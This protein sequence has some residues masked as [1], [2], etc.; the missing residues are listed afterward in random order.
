M[1]HSSNFKR[2]IQKVS[3]PIS[4]LLLTV[5]ISIYLPLIASFFNEP[6]FKALPLVLFVSI[7][8]F[9]FD[10]V[11]IYV[12]TVIY[13]FLLT[14]LHLV[15]FQTAVAHPFG[16]TLVLF[17]AFLIF[18]IFEAFLPSFGFSRL[19]LFMLWGAAL[20]S[21]TIFLEWVAIILGYQST[22]AFL[23]NSDLIRGYKVTNSAFFINY[24]WGY[25]D[26]NGQ[27]IYGAN[28]PTLGSQSGS[29]LSLMAVFLFLPLL[30]IDTLTIRRAAVA[31]FV[32]FVFLATASMMMTIII[33]ISLIYLLFMDKWSLLSGLRLRL[34]LLL[35]LIVFHDFFISLIFYRIQNLADL[36][37]YV[38][39]FNVFDALFALNNFEFF[40]GSKYNFLYYSDA[41]L[42]GLFYFGGFCLF[43]F[44]ITPLALHGIRSH[45][46][47]NIISN[48]KNKWAD[49]DRDLINLNRIS[50]FNVGVCFIGLVHYSVSLE[51]G[52][53]QVF[54]FFIGLL[55][56]TSKFI[57]LKFWVPSDE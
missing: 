22:L 29:Q 51:L 7:F 38:N 55:M 20:V 16:F 9:C 10:K 39:A 53:A 1:T 2:F 54:S 37:E 52:I 3:C 17:Q 36:D 48:D 33:G 25:S 50:F 56:F 8:L 21:F 14:L 49:D 28:G 34:F 42:L 45:L 27:T 15:N 40:F 11:K 19:Y 30:K 18:K 44:W 31:T 23:F 13:F 12:H 4:M 57:F 47:R 35:F 6:A 24:I 41:G 32:L 43:A 5:L 46:A 26:I